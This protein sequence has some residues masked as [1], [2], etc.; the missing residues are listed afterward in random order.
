MVNDSLKNETLI[1]G[2]EE[3]KESKL[4]ENSK[5]NNAAQDETCKW[6]SCM[7][8]AKRVGVIPPPPGNLNLLIKFTKIGLGPS[9]I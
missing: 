2:K 7:C 8:E 4:M 1:T 5:K 3:G 6:H 9:W